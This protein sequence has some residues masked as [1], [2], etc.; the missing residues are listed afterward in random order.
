MALQKLSTKV[1]IVGSGPSA[2]TAAIYAARALLAPVLFEGFL[3]NGVAAGGQVRVPACSLVAAAACSCRRG[4]KVVASRPRRRP[5]RRRDQL[6]T[7]TDVENFPGFPEGILGSEI[8]DKFRRAPPNLRP[9]SPPDHA[10]PPAPPPARRAQSVRFGTQIFTETVT[11]VDLS[12]RP[13][14]VL[15]DTKDVSA[16]ALIVATGAVAKRLDFPGSHEGAGGYWNRG[17]SACAVCDGAAPLFRNRPLAVLGGGDS[18]MEEANFLTK[19]GSVVYIIHRRGEFRASQIMRQR[20]LDNP[21]IRVLWHTVVLAA[22]GAEGGG[23]AG[24]LA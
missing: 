3:A 9:R 21:K 6:T 23:G 20:A 24:T 11:R 14:R 5:P 7:T 2:H 22:E 13:F 16:D 4:A 10:C 15:T 12:S 18:A 8:C 1:C 17:I 19:Y